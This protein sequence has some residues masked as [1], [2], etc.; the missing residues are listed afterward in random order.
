MDLL[1]R[2][3]DKLLLAQAGFLAQRRLAR[4]VKLNKSEAT[5]LIASVLQEHIRDGLHSVAELMQLGKTML[6]RCHVLPGVPELLHEV[7]VEG[8]FPDGTFLVTVHDP[9]CT[10][11]GDVSAALFGSLLPT[12][13]P[14][15]FPPTSVPEHLPGALVVAA[16]APPIILNQGRDRISLRVTN[17]GDRPIQVGSHYPFIETNPF[18]RFDRLAA[19]GRRLDIAAGTGE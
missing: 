5:A 9:V 4:G 3:R 18:L 12:P 13:A 2:E 10:P 1:P 7:M 19:L 11:E 17:T 16:K 15:L 8:C 14:Q 6:G